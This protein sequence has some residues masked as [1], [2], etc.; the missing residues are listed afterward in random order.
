[1]KKVRMS[2]RKRTRP[3]KKMKIY[4][5]TNTALTSEKRYALEAVH[6]H[7]SVH[8][9]LTFQKGIMQ[10]FV[11]RTHSVPMRDE[12]AESQRK[13]KSRQA[14]QTRRSTQGVTLTDIKE[15][16]TTY[17]LSHQSREK[18]E[19]G[20]LDHRS[21]PWRSFSDAKGDTGAVK[22]AEVS[23]KWNIIDKEGNVEHQVDNLAE[24]SNS[25][26]LSLSESCASPNC[27]SSFR[28]GGRWWRDENENPVEEATQLSAKYQLRE[29]SPD[30][31]GSLYTTESMLAACHRGLPK[32]R[33]AE[34]S[35]GLG[36][37]GGVEGPGR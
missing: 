19:E 9:R 2:Q 37:V 26:H 11:P 17:S 5:K 22:A 1:M 6:L 15:A 28:D 18:E 24:S 35:R 31:E 33:R 32:L 30:V 36:L 25:S 14:R 10:A 27:N 21:S 3:H 20:T 12:D 13:A 29:S 4:Q 23:L 8:Q 34:R 7:G 16:Q